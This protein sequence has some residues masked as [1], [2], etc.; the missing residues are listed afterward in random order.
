LS[1]FAITKIYFI[2]A[3]ILLG[4]SIGDMRGKQGGT[5]YSRNRYANYTRNKTIPVNPNTAKQSAVRSAL[6]ALS[7][8]W[9]SLSASDRN[10]WAAL[11]DA[12]APTNVFGQAFKYT[13]FNVYIKSNQTLQSAGLPTLQA[14]D[15]IP[16]SF[17]VLETSV[18][19]DVSDNKLEYAALFDGDPVTPEGLVL[20]VQATPAV[21]ASV[22]NASVERTYRY[23][24]TTAQE[25]DFTTPY[26]LLSDWTSVFGS[27]GFVE[28]NVIYIRTKMISLT[29]GL[30]SPWLVNVAGIVA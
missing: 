13:P 10:A 27:D 30:T 26:N 20:V 12:L 2:M 14:P 7:S 29:T 18:G 23:I 1:I 16:P 17:P 11:A 3:K 22:S 6:G 9:R 28:G 4:A 24:L 8:A 5:V 15:V 21:S 25:Q 19:G